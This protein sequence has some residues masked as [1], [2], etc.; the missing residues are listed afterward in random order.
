MNIVIVDNDMAILRSLELLL[1]KDGHQ[2]ILFTDP[3][4]ALFHFV[5]ENPVDVLLLDYSMPEMNGDELVGLLKAEIPAGCRV[6]MMSAHCD[7]S[8]RVDSEKLGIDALLSKPVEFSELKQAL[9]DPETTRR[10]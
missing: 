9:H 10:Q 2:V 5:R 7:L 3:R 4:G 8:Q 6:I 1:A